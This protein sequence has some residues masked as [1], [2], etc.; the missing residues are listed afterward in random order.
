MKP[1]FKRGQGSRVQSSLHTY[2]GIILK[3]K[4]NWFN[5][6][7]KHFVVNPSVYN[8]EPLTYCVYW[9]CVWLLPTFGFLSRRFFHIF[10]IRSG[11]LRRFWLQDRLLLAQC[12]PGRGKRPASYIQSLCQ[13][14]NVPKHVLVLQS[15][16]SEMTHLTLLS[17]DFS[18]VGGL[19]MGL[20]VLT[21]LP[22]CCSFPAL[23]YLFLLGLG[24]PYFL[25]IWY[26]QIILTHV[27]VHTV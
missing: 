17:T 15:I 14:V 5:L 18:L 1:K 24:V 21:T 20:L 23:L 7:W 11:F 8:S 6:R 25:R 22:W 27:N 12:S 16:V 13:S 4:C 10:L 3:Q 19:V 2:H 9:K 26:K